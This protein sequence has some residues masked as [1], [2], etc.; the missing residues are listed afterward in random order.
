ML[1][2]EKTRPLALFGPFLLRLLGQFSS[3]FCG[4]LRVYTHTHTHTQG[5]SSTH[6][7]THT[8]VFVECGQLRVHTHT[9]TH[10]QGYSSKMFAPTQG[11][12]IFTTKVDPTLGSTF[13]KLILFEKSRVELEFVFLIFTT[14]VRKHIGN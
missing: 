8:R 12:F 10:T 6:T 9:H 11:F 13:F 1:P 4:Q 5:Y 14:R 2:Q 3:V 7:H